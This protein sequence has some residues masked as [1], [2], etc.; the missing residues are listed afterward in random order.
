[1]KVYLVWFKACSYQGAGP[2][3]IVR[4]FSTLKSAQ[5]FVIKSEYPPVYS[6]EEMEVVEEV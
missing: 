2:N 4:I 1:M 5:D 3:H 6:I